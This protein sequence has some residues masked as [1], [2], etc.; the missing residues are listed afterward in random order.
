MILILLVG[1]LGKVLGATCPAGQKQYIYNFS[2]C[3]N[4]EEQWQG[5]PIKRFGTCG[6]N[7]VTSA[8]KC[9][10]FALI[11]GKT[12]HTE[13][14]ST[15]YPT[16]CVVVSAG[17]YYNS[18]QS[19]VE[20]SN[21]ASCTC[22]GDVAEGT[23]ICAAGTYQNPDLWCLDCPQGR[24]QNS[25]SK[26][27]CKACPEGYKSKTETAAVYC[28]PTDEQIG[29]TI[30]AAG[31]YENSGA[32]EACPSGQYSEIGRSE[33]TDQTRQW[34]VLPTAFSKC[35]DDGGSPVMSGEECKV[36]ARSVGAPLGWSPTNT[37]QSNWQH[38]EYPPGCFRY[39]NTMF[40]NTMQ[41]T[42]HNCTSVTNPNFHY[43]I[44]ASSPTEGWCTPGKYFNSGACED[45]PIGKYQPLDGKVACNDCPVGKT[46]SAVGAS[47]VTQCDT[48]VTSWK[49][50]YYNSGCLPDDDQLQGYIKKTIGTCDTLIAT[51]AECLS[52]AQ[53][54]GSTAEALIVVNSEFNIKDCY[55]RA[56]GLAYFNT[57]AT[58]L[59]ISCDN[60]HNRCVCTALPRCAAG[61]YQNNALECV[62]CP[63]GQYSEAGKSTCENCPSGQKPNYDKTECQPD[64][65]QLQG[66]YYKTTGTCGKPITTAEE[67]LEAAQYLGTPLTQTP[68]TVKWTNQASG[69]IQRYDGTTVFNAAYSTS[70]CEEISN[71]YTYR[72]I[73]GSANSVPLCAE[74]KY[75]NN[76]LECAA[77]AS[78]KVSERGK[79]QCKSCPAGKYKNNGTLHTELHESGGYQC[80]EGGLITDEVTCL[81]AVQ[82]FDPNKKALDGII[83]HNSKPTG[84]YRTSGGFAYFNRDTATMP[85]NAGESRCICKPPSCLKCPYGM[86]SA[87]GS[88]ALSDCVDIPAAGCVSNDAAS[89]K[90]AYSELQ[91]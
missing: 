38:S 14:Y 27:T 10:T 69:C 7:T 31:E 87:T 64:D 4:E 55:M 9:Q 59:S 57:H 34:K 48:C 86:W 36:A 39:G 6:S 73:C 63:N 37:P 65:D 26:V 67:C 35:G 45:C 53:S 56:N 83:Y 8:S 30:C 3:I 85:C 25:P 58:G 78:D 43:C 40:F 61:K 70:E 88:T 82:Q 75:Q 44:C 2:P 32:C 24:Y 12:Y 81:E 62:A 54:L 68:Y 90:S 18:A 49:P 42:N 91:C 16:G 33:C 41:N 79:S 47:S 23:P 51:R 46:T 80:E 29:S 66:Y 77:C 21:F 5:S 17:A 72:C 60:V 50:D 22:I 76:A 28:I 1:F 89:L 15:D 71:D 84:C 19:S 13:I 11:H 74:G 20:C 52:A